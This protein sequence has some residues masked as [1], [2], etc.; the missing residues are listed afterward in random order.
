MYVWDIYDS[1]ELLTD[2]GLG[3]SIPSSNRKANNK[4]LV[5]PWG[6]VSQHSQLVE[7]QFQSR[8]KKTKKK[9]ERDALEW[10]SLSVAF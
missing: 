2:C 8:K 6:C 5:S 9:K 10:G 1:L 4:V 3:S 7:S